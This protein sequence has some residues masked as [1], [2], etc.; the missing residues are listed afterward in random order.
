MGPA[1]RAAAA[2]ARR[3]IV[4]IAEQRGDAR[5]AARARSSRCSRT[6]RSSARARAARTRPGCRCSPSASRSPRSRSTSRPARSGSTAIA[7]IHDVGRVINPLGASSQIEGGIIQGIGHTLSEERLHDPRTGRDPHDEPRRL[8]AADDR[9]RAGDRQRA[10][11]RAR[12]APDEPRL[13]GARRAADRPD[14]GGDRERDPRR[15]RRR[16][17]AAADHPRGDAARAPRGRGAAAREEQRGAP[18][19]V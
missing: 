16:R 4:E 19:G 5:H 17:A 9:R 10:R 8:P 18:A 1:V 11:R 3:Q 7:A 13:E 15:D 2:D 6:R 12:R 14:R